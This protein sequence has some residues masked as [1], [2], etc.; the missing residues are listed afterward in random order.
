MGLHELFIHPL[1]TNLEM[2]FYPP[3]QKTPPQFL[4][5]MNAKKELLRRMFAERAKPSADKPLTSLM[6]RVNTGTTGFA[7]GA[8]YT[9]KGKKFELRCAGIDGFYDIEDDVAIVY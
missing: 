4:A 6:S 1:Q 3:T 7:R 2:N 5:G 9:D 8:P